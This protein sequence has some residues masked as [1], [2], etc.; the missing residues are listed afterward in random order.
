MP[1]GFQS[2]IG[3][4]YIFL[5]KVRIIFSNI[6]CMFKTNSPAFIDFDFDKA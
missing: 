1:F 2:D 5:R 3:D 6:I 4:E